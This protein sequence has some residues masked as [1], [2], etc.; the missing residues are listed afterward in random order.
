MTILDPALAQRFIDKTANLFEYNINIM[1][2]RGIIIAS[3]DASRIG[4]FHEVAFRMLNGTLGTGVV[5][6]NQNYL[7]TKHGV[8]LFIECKNKR[9]GVIG[10]S[11]NPDT[12]HVFAGLMK[13]FMEAMLEYEIQMIGER[14]RRDKTEQFLYNL[15]FEDTT[16]IS[17]AN[18][19]AD[20]LGIIKDILRACIIIKYDYDDNPKKILEALVNAE[21]YSQQDII[22][23]A[24]NDDIIVFKALNYNTIKLGDAIRDFRYIIEEYINSFIEKLP[25]SCRANKISFWVGSMQTDFK[26]YRG[27][28]LQAQKLGLHIKENN[29]VCFLNDHILDYYR[30]IVTI[31]VYDNIF[32]TYDLLFS[33]EEKKQ[34]VETV[35]CLKK[36]NYNVVNSSKELYIH[37]N[38]LL[39]RLNKLKDV[40]NIE[41]ISNASDREFLNELAYYFK[42]K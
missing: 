14:C 21:G 17:L 9:E 42:L 26:N 28:F 1:N 37:R 3:K 23:L 4:D 12:V 19:I 34:I 5:D 10:V 18:A 32:N 7:G 20:E 13:T 6:D 31:K 41:P 33:R 8:N 40:L 29:G 16:D 36:N 30:R 25:D 15:L 24:R 38:T 35:E 11:G 27:S 39:F 2:A 22:T